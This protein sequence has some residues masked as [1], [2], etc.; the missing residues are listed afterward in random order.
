MGACRPPFLLPYFV[1]MSSSEDGWPNLVALSLQQKSYRA[2][3]E[4]ALCSVSCLSRQRVTPPLGNLT[5]EG[6]PP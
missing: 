6:L 5:W 1:M 4:N 2:V 3:N